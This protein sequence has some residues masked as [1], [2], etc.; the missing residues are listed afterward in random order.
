[1]VKIFVQRLT[2]CFKGEIKDFPGYVWK[3]YNEAAKHRAD[4]P[5]NSRGVFRKIFFCF[6]EPGRGMGLFR[7]NENPEGMILP[8]DVSGAGNRI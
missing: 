8:G 6:P 5:G 2:G 1:M 4:M 3:P 7:A